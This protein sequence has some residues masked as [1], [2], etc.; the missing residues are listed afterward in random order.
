MPQGQTGGRN[1]IGTAQLLVVLLAFCWGLVWVATA[2]A[3]HEVKPWTLRTTCIGIGAATLFIV[4]R[5][6]GFDLTVPRRERIHV[7]VGGFFNIA[8]FHVLTAFAQL[9]GA[10]SRTIVI[11]YSMPIWATLLS[12][13]LLHER[14]DRSRILAFSL[15]VAGIGVLVW[16]LFANGVPVFALYSLTAAVGWAFAIV[17]MKWMRVTVPPLA[18][19]AWQLLFSFGILSIGTLAFE[20]VPRLWPLSTPALVAVL[21]IGILGVGLAHFLFWSIVGRLSTVAAALGMLLVPVVGVISSTIVL[22]ERPTTPDIV[23][24][25]LIF[26]AAASVLLW[27]TVGPTAPE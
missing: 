25:A 13:V 14:L 20:G 5:L 21:Y 22:G 18:N 1:A 16:P 12:V 6:A 15:C 23:G 3:L 8:A 9:N 27:P 24:F 4:A 19:A 11:T 7:M 26:A 17:Y 10:T 2:F